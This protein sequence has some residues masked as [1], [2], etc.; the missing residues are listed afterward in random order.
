MTLLWLQD[1]CFIEFVC[2]L[3]FFLMHA[4]NDYFFLIKKVKKSKFNKQKRDLNVKQ[5][6]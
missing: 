6:F 2:I 3:L 4:I 1:D 5:K